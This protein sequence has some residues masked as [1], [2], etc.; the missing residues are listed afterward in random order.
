MIH[1]AERVYALL[2]RDIKQVT[3][4]GDLPSL[5]ESGIA[6]MLFGGNASTEYF[7]FAPDPGNSILRPVI[8][9][10]AR[11]GSYALAAS[12]IQKIQDTLHRYCDDTFLSIMMVG[13][14]M[15]LGRSPEKLCEFQITF[16]IQL[17]E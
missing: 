8:K 14:P 1:V 11:E 6:L 12:W 13:A 17:K 2:P 7:G 9:F 10:I 4:I 15:F 16:S 5:K 3:K